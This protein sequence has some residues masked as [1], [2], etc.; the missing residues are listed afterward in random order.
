MGHM[1]QELTLRDR[2]VSIME[3]MTCF[4]HFAYFYCFKS[5]FIINISMGPTNYSHVLMKSGLKLHTHTI[6]DSS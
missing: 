2:S 1:R 5:V 3:A 6:Q 4:T